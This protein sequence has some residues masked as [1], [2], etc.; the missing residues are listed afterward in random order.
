M[1]NDNNIILSLQ[2]LREKL[3][4]ESYKIREELYIQNLIKLYELGYIDSNKFEEELYNSSY[5]CLLNQ[6]KNSES[7]IKGHVK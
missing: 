3:K 7:I 5:A 6:N 4:E 1:L 2:L